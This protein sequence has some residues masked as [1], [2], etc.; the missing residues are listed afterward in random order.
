MIQFFQNLKLRERLILFMVFV[1]AIGAAYFQFEYEVQVNRLS[2]LKVQKE[3]LD[4]EVQTYRAAAGMVT[5][6]LLTRDIQEAQFEVVKLQ[7]EIA[8]LKS[9]MSGDTVDIIRIL[10]RVA[11][12]NNVEFQSVDQNERQVTRGQFQYRQ[13]NISIGLAASYRGVME[14]IRSLDSIPAILSIE[15]LSLV[16]EPSLLP[17][18]QANMAIRLFVL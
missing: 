11:Q 7:D 9:R 17:K 3:E 13:V 1:V 6:N 2:A 4:R 16:R 8:F 5:S 18:I 12:N 14:F 15:D 10:K